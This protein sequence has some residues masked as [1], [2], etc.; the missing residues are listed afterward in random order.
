MTQ[1]AAETAFAGQVPPNLTC[2]F[3]RRP[4]QDVFY[5]AAS[6]FACGSCAARVQ[7]I[8]DRNVITRQALLMGAVA[9]TATAAV[10]AAAWAIIT[11][12]THMELGIVASLIGFAVAKAIFT[13]AGKRRGRALQVLAV[14]LSLAGILGGKFVLFGMQ[15]NR[16]L[17][18]LGQHFDL[19]RI[20]SVLVGEIQKHPGNL[21]DPFDLVWIG[22]A[23]YAAWR[24]LALPQISVAGPYAYKPADGGD[25]QFQTLEPALTPAPPNA[26]PASGTQ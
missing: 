3:C 2:G 8:G 6:R 19:G 9:G 11:D 23:V 12:S 10:G 24:L 20:L 22:I 16:A 21:F 17:T 1:P 18:Q 15:I 4:V 7:A 14:A 25:L 13:A 26:P 5:R